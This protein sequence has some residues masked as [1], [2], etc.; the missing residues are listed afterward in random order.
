VQHD[1][2]LGIGPLLELVLAVIPD[3]DVTPAVLAFAD[4]AFEAA[5]LQR[6]ILGVDGQVIF[7]R[8]FRDALRQRP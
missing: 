3:A 5:V 2:Y 7:C 6:V 8:V 4:I 1:L